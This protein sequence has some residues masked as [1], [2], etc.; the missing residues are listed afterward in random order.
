MPEQE[1]R[2]SLTSS[3]RK[4]FTERENRVHPGKDDK[5]L[6][7]WNG[8]MIDALARA[9]AAL[10]EP[11][12]T[13]AAVR[14]ADFIQKNLQRAG[15][16]LLHTWRRGPDKTGVAK[17]DAYLDDYACLA[18]ALVSLYEATFD[19]Q[20]L[21]EAARLADL[22]LDHFADKQNGGFYFT[23]DDH[24]QLIARNRE[25]A[26]SST[27]AASAMAVTALVRLA[28]LS[29]E[30]KYQDAAEQAIRS[31]VGFL[32]QAPTAMGQTLLALDFQLGPTYELVLAGDAKEVLPGLRRRFLPNKVLAAATPSPPPILAALLAG[33]SS[34]D[35]QPVL[36]VCEGFTCQ[37]PAV[38]SAEIAA[39]L[40]E[41]AP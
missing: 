1:L 25:I 24:E 18:N 7:A 36:F 30:K 22:M 17:L 40:D 14:A 32:K 29:G 3:R 6:V 33:K 12:F 20:R 27:P 19:A 8:L 21:V 2:E 38:G 15:G 31:A 34:D 41:L 26:D 35:P 23:A 28:K 37:R 4:L 9:G 5:I 13:E 11:R 10:G 16:R 39:K